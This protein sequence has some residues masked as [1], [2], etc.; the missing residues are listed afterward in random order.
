MLSLNLTHQQR[1]VP[2]VSTYVAALVCLVCSAY[3]LLLSH[4]GDHMSAPCASVVCPEVNQPS[5]FI[6]QVS[7][8]GLAGTPHLDLHGLRATAVGRYVAP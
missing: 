7:A 6:Q 3:L 1:D 4:I 2:V 8:I 5:H